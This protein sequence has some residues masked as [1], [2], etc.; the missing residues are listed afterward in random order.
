MQGIAST[1]AVQAALRVARSATGRRKV[2]KFEGHYHG[3]SDGILASYHPTADQLVS[4]DG[5]LAVSSGQL[6]PQ[7]TLV[8]QWNDFDAVEQHRP[9]R[10]VPPKSGRIPLIRGLRSFS[11]LATVRPL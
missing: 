10:E 2:I 5:P 8:A 9:G 7:E 4:S 3:W 6:P 11:G 1:E